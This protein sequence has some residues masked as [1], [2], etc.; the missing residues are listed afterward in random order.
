VTAALAAAPLLEAARTRVSEESSKFQANPWDY[1]ANLLIELGTTLLLLGIALGFLGYFLKAYSVKAKGDAAQGIATVT[2][3][4]TN[5][6]FTAAQQPYLTATSP[7]VANDIVNLGNDAFRFASNT[8]NQA[9][10]DLGGIAT[11][12]DDIPKALVQL[13]SQG[14]SIA[15]NGF[16]GLMSEAFSDIFILVFPYAIIFGGAMLTAGVAM[17][18]VRYVWDASIAPEIREWLTVKVVRPVGSYTRRLLQLTPDPGPLPT[19][20]PERPRIVEEGKKVELALPLRDPEPPEAPGT[21]L[22]AEP[23]SEPVP[24]K[25]TLPAVSTE[26]Q[27]A[28]LG[29][30]VTNAKDR[31]RAALR[32]KRNEQPGPVDPDYVGWAYRQIP[33]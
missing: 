2:G 32:R 16:L 9:W 5:V 8:A 3:V 15:I 4:F 7:N 27:E 25:E 22:D 14:P 20:P 21:I 10:A 28:A 31:L 13:I 29:V 19:D 17:T 18:V 1:V 24:V 33:A 23:T 12:I 30:S 26:Q 6:S 11:A